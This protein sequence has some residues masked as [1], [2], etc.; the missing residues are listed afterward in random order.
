MIYSIR[1][2][3]PT[4]KQVIFQ[5]GFNVILA[6]RTK[7]SMKKDSRNGLGKTTLIEIV[8]FCLGGNKGETLDKKQMENWSFTIEIDLLGQKYLVTRNTE[9]K[10]FVVIEGDCSGWPIQ[11]KYDN[12]FQQ[13]VMSCR[14]W[15]AVLGK[16][17]F[18]IPLR[19]NDAK[20][21]PTFRSIISYFARKNSQSGAFL[22]PFQHN[23]KQ[24]P[25]DMQVNN[26]F[27]LNLSWEFASK[28]RLLK[29]RE[30][31]VKQIRKELKSGLL[32][33][34]IEPLG[35]L[36][37]KRIHLEE[38]VKKGEEQLA[39]FRV[40]T[41]YRELEKN[42]NFLTDQIHE[43]VNNNVNDKR[44][45][46]HYEASLKEELEAR[47]DIVKRIYEEAGLTFPEAITKKLDDVLQFHRQVIKNRKDFLST[48][49]KK[50]E[51]IISEREQKVSDLTNQRADLMIVLQKHGALDE[52]VRLHSNHQKIVAELKNIEIKIDNLREFEQGR[53][54]MRVE[55]ELIYQQAITD[56]NERKTQKEEAI[57]LFNANSQ[58]LYS[59]PGMLSID[60]DKNGL[61][62][63]VSIER[64]GS[65]GIGNMKIFCYDL[66]LAQLW[67]RKVKTKV[68]LLHDSIIFADVDERQKALA[69]ELAA[70]EAEKR[71]FQYI[72]TMNSD[73]IPKSDLSKNFNL[74]R[75]VRL[76]LTDATE[77]GGLLGIRF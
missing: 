64:S 51:H 19:G 25:W 63:D 47:Q 7:N 43:L 10:G 57:L 73:S 62:F 14:D 45:L 5:P 66:M 32:P 39:N 72:C 41:Q 28:L 67:A 61:K 76:K 29:D 22:N 15:T 69:L 30:R 50:L 11:P 54:T 21:T 6:E 37:A 35:V 20:Y 42:A 49:I 24:Q 77:N 26:A 16:L 2:D 8:H 12:K 71:G 60:L 23:K 27:L 17:S 18:N 13:N 31:V 3:Q 58:A 59:V 38:R 52:H 56:L 33:N 36:E 70:I 9:K 40:H 53:S 1:S 55:Q 65:H 44:L 48:E 34:V 4:F 68:Y 74:D 75:Y 46:E